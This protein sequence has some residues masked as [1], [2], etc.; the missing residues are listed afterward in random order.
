MGVEIKKVPATG[1]Q[2]GLIEQDKNKDNKGVIQLT[3]LEKD[4]NK[5][6]QTN[7]NNSNGI[8]KTVTANNWLKE[9]SLKDT[10]K[11]LFGDFM[12][13]NELCIMFG[14]SNTGKSILA[15]QIADSISSEKEF[16]PLHME[17]K[18][19]SVL[20]LDCELSDK[21]FE[22]RYSD[23]GKFHYQFSE[24][25]L[26]SEIDSEKLINT[27]EKT[28][29][30]EQLIE[31]IE[32]GIKENSTRLLIIDNLTYLSSENE[33]AKDALPLMKH[34]KGLKS[35]YNL[36]ILILGHTPKRDL[37]KPLS[38][39]D[40]SGSKMLINF[41]DSAFAIGES[42]QGSSIRYLK[43]IKVRNTSINYDKD[44][45]IVFSIEKSSHFLKFEFM[46]FGAEYEHLKHISSEAKE[47]LDNE[48]VELKKEKPHLNNSELAKR[49]GTYKMKVWR[50]LEVNKQE[51]QNQ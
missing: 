22:M 8:L 10:P 1:E 16:N 19:N 44:N 3:D 27:K 31:S 6:V 12:F 20:Y 43:Q 51:F 41:C 7:T 42:T 46:G 13:E 4:H 39:N 14:D 24:N 38:K 18:N 33:K 9:A 26:R 29:F 17:L 32:Q 23:H 25:F 37:T 35:K 5:H 50:V 30:E 28:S 21:Q 11:R 40:L 48:I 47:K 15:V 49:L 36:S 2:Q 45:V 34:L